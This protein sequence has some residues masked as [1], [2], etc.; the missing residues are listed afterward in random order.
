MSDTKDN[1]S[2][3][4]VKGLLG[5]LPLFFLKFLGA[6]LVLYLIHLKAGF[7]YMRLIAWGASPLLAI[8]GHRLVMENALK[9]TEEI[10][11]NPVVYI[12]LVLA[13]SGIPWKKKIRP[14]IFG[15]LILSAANILTVFLVFMSYYMK[16]ETL[17]TSTEFFNLTINFFLPILLWFTLMPVGRLFTPRSPKA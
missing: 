2:I 7:I 12:S 8:F 15:V 6:S 11:L 17:W 3:N 9:V 10:S 14:A 1:S 5:S 16:S 4:P 13:V